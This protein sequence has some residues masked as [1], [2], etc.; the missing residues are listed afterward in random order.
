MA[1]ENQV[2]EKLLELQGLLKRIWE[3]GAMSESDFHTKLNGIWRSALFWRHAGR[4]ATWILNQ[5]AAVEDE[6]EAEFSSRAKP[7][8]RS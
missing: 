2:D 1:G 4:S 7:R 6:L 8:N 5:L 3:A